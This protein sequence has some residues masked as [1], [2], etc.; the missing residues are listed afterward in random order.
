MRSAPD[1]AAAGRQEVAL[2]AAIRDRDPARRSH[3]VRLLDCFE[4]E[5]PG[6]GPHVC[7]VFDVLGDD[8]LSL[9]R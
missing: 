1:Y 3:C 4:H 6:G 5:G 9:M 8:L 7:E 2:L